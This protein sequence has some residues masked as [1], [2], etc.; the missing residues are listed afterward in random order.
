[1][2]PTDRRTDELPPLSETPP[3]IVDGVLVDLRCS[4][5]L[6]RNDQLL[7][8]HPRKLQSQIHQALH[9]LRPYL[10][11]RR[12]VVC[13]GSAQR[14]ACYHSAKQ[15]RS[16]RPSRPRC[17][18]KCACKP[19]R[20]LLRATRTTQLQRLLNQAVQLRLHSRC[21]RVL[22]RRPRNTARSAVEAAATVIVRAAATARA[23]QALL[24]QQR[25]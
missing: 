3:D 22:A 18:R 20:K 6:I 10:Q 1:M 15:R 24:A 19:R 4:V 13:R 14:S 23:L 2:S 9:R 25:Q 5:A 12:W 11:L 16:R 17:S 7:L 21:R 8:L